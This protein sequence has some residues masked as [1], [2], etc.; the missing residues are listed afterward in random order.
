MS[1]E[2]PPEKLQKYKELVEW[3]ALPESLRRPRD[4]GSYMG[5]KNLT[6]EE[7][8]E[9]RSMPDY[10]KDVFYA[11]K[12][13]AKSQT[14]KLLHAVYD[15]IIEKKSTQDL[16]TWFRL[17]YEVEDKD[18]QKEVINF[19]EKLSNER[20]KEILQRIERKLGI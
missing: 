1:T 19:D 17:V 10:D 11:A 8:M 3:A 7:V 6:S 16:T 18:I 9:L 13:W 20:K 4:I 14:P 15:K 5:V 12:N 2:L